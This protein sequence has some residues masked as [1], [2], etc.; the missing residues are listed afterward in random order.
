MTEVSLKEL[1]SAGAHFGHQTR[2]WNPKMKPYLYDAK[3]GVHIF[4]LAQTKIKLEEALEVLKKYAKEGKSILFV[5]TKKQA[6]EMVRELAEGTGSFYV[7]ERWLGG[8]LTNFDYIK[9]STKKLQ[10]LKAGLAEGKFNDRTK[11]ERLL[12]ER[13]MRR[14]ERFFGGIETMTKIPDLMVVIDTKKERT[15]VKEALATGVEIM[16]LVDSNSDPTQIDYPIPMNDDATRAL[17]YVLSLMEEAILEGKRK[18]QSYDKLKIDPERSRT[19]QDSK[20]KT[21]AS[22]KS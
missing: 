10:E 21:E 2:R 20:L 5:G 16:G 8:A 18:T 1:I 7:N 13:E 9:R 3:E 11:R 14:L 4:D 22:K 15:A 19:G 17:E 6:K 12:I